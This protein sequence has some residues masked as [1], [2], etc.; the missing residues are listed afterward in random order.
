MR[1]YVAHPS[2]ALLGQPRFPNHFKNVLTLASDMIR[3]LAF[4]HSNDIIHGQVK[5]DNVRYFRHPSPLYAILQTQTLLG[6]EFVM[7]KV[8]GTK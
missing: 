7:L 3:A 4:L 8:D 6:V 2:L 5:P 1:E